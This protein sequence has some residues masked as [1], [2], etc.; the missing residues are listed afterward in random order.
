MEPASDFNSKAPQSVI[1]KIE[2]LYRQGI[3]HRWR[4]E[5]EHSTNRSPEHIAAFLGDI[6]TLRKFLAHNPDLSGSTKR[7]L[8]C[9]VLMGGDY[10]EIVPSLLPDI[11]ENL[12][13]I[14]ESYSFLQGLAHAGSVRT[15]EVFLESGANYLD[16][17]YW[18]PGELVARSVLPEQ[19]QEIAR[20]LIT[21]GARENSSFGTANPEETQELEQLLKHELYYKAVKGS[22][23]ELEKL[24]PA[25]SSRDLSRA[26]ALAVGRMREP[27]IDLPLEAGAVPFYALRTLEG[28]LKH[29]SL[30]SK[31][32]QDRYGQPTL[33]IQGAAMVD[34]ISRIRKEKER[35]ERTR[36]RFLA[37]ALSLVR[38]ITQ[39]ELSSY[40]HALP[41]E[42]RLELARYLTEGYQA[43]IDLAVAQ[44]QAMRCIT[45]ILTNF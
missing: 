11:I 23:Q 28:I 20:L 44:A 38:V 18:F 22:R 43:P 32:H 6:P 21:Y 30:I 8:L 34:Y 27:V 24:L 45:H 2:L 10:P 37:R 41:S 15:L 42:L 1:D 14:R 4:L 12:L 17:P 36:R 40:I 3:D 7:E 9:F 25:S 16:L 29:L 35:R 31:L 39:P 5:Q 13:T 33:P 19:A 26:L